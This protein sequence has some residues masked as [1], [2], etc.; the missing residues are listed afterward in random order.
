MLFFS[1]VTVA[2]E[3]R[4]SARRLEL[5]TVKVQVF[6]CSQ[7][8]PVFPLKDR[9]HSITRTF[10]GISQ[11]AIIIYDAEEMFRVNQSISMLGF[12]A[13]IYHSLERA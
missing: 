13:V 9:A 11:C 1:D 10:P 5:I 8:P 4:F 3:S 12:P 7:L 6:G 2:H